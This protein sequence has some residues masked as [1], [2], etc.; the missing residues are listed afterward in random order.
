M[1]IEHKVKDVEFFC[2]NLVVAHLFKENIRGRDKILYF[3]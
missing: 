3:S 1:F 2:I